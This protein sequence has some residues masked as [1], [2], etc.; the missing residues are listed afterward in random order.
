MRAGLADMIMNAHVLHKYLSDDPW[1]P[2]SLSKRTV[3]E[4]RDGLKFSGPII[5]DDMQMKAIT[6]LKLKTSPSVAAIAAGSSL[7]I[8]SN[9]RSKFGIDSVAKVNDRLFRAVFN[10]E[11]S[12]GVIVERARRASDFRAAL[13]NRI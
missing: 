8:Y 5:S 7:L 11:L 12:V 13:F 10:D 4:I 1:V 3:S 2:T 6:N 9:H